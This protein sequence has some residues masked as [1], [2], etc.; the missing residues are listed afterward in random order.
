MHALLVRI[1]ESFWFLPAVLGVVA[2]VAAQ[3]L[4]TLDREVLDGRVPAV[5]FLDAL[6]AGGGRSI[7]TTIG[8]AMLTVAG[9]SFSIT[10][11]VLAT[12]SST[13]GPRL[14]RNFTADRANQLVLAAFTST[15][16]YAMVVLRTVHTDVDDGDPFVPV[17]AI[18][19]AVLLAVLDVGVLVFFIHHIASSTQ[20]TSLQRQVQTDLRAAVDEA[21]R[22]GDDD[23]RTIAPVVVPEDGWSAVRAAADGS[24]QSV[25]WRALTAWAGRND[26]LV[27]VVATPGRYVIQGDVVVRVRADG[28]SRPTV[29]TATARTLRAAVVL[30]TARTPVQDVEFALQQLVEIAVRGLASGSNDPYTAVSA[31]DMATPVLVPLWRDRAAVTALLGPDGAPRVLQH[32]PA[33]E[34][35]VAG[36]FATVGHYGAGQPLVERAADR[37]ADRL[38]QQASQPRRGLVA[39]MRP[40][41]ADRGPGTPG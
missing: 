39:T 11:S 10:I 8:T 25:E 9:T 15:F 41:H 19:V 31:L 33:P 14:V 30:G 1:R 13:Y 5:P 6:S 16:L 2:I 35:L 17:V 22:D 26:R 29:D 27:D 20:I 7:L 23:R 36:L 18:H 21:Y 4:V 40:H 3:L 12:T 28:G 38:E 32:W 24:V 34:D 37:L